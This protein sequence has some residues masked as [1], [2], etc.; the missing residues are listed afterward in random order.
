M[1]RH[2]VFK[3]HNLVI[4]GGAVPLLNGIVGCT[5][6]SLRRL[7]AQLSTDGDAVDWNLL[8]IHHDRHRGQDGTATHKSLRKET[9][10]KNSF[11]LKF[12]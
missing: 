8:S 11:I 2:Q 3:L 5:L 9:R 12:K 6:F 10:E 1:A 4:D 7:A